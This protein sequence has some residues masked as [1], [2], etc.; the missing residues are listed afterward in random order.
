MF[1]DV[2]SHRHAHSFGVHV[3]TKPVTDGEPSI[4]QTGKQLVR[5]LVDEV[6]N[7]GR[8]DLIDELYDPQLAPAARRWIEP[9]LQSFS[10]VSMRIVEL[11][12]EE[13]RVA[14]RFVCSGTHT[15]PWLGQSATGRRF[16]NIAEVYFFRIAGG[17]ISHAWGLED[18]RTRLAQ[19]GLKPRA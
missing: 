15:G 8:L 17:R 4:P 6:L 13:D 11:I 10:D 7:A 2:Y 16:T 18:T 19:L 14:A 3:T 5:R 9:F 1:R 12:A